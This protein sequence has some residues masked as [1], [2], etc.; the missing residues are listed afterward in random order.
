[1]DTTAS[2]QCEICSSDMEAGG[3]ATQVYRRAGSVITVT[4]IPA[5]RVCPRC[6]NAVLEWEIA[7]QV[8]DLVTPLFLWIESHSMSKPVITV[9]FPSNGVA[10]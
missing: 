10:A 5:V 4:G 2:D 6:Q 3:E 9:V 7:Q 1:M 8:E